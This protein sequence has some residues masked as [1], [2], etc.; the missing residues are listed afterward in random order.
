MHPALNRC[1]Q[2]AGL[3]TVRLLRSIA[4]PMKKR[5]ISFLS[6]F[7][8]SLSLSGADSTSAGNTTDRPNILWV[9]T[10]DNTY[11]Y[12]SAYGDPLARTPHFDRIAKEGILFERAYSTSAVCAPT[13]ASIITG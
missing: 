2:R 12:N 5:F 1:A 11:T 8:L 3:R 10:E 7:A 6:F 13:R 9:V 4:L